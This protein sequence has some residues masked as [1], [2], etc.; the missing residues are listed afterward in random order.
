MGGRVIRAA[1]PPVAVDVEA[2]GGLH[3]H[4]VSES[5]KA[6]ERVSVA[7]AARGVGS[8]GLVGGR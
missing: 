1:P 3:G 5:E 7:L 6:R 8:R 4:G 2:H